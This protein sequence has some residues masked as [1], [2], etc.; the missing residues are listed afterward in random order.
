MNLLVLKKAD[1]SSA[2]FVGSQTDQ[3]LRVMFI[4]LKPDTFLPVN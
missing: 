1:Y 4:C 2:F 3:F